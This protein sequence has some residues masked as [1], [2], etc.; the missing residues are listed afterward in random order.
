MSH[1]MQQL[2]FLIVITNAGGQGKT[3]LARLCKSLWLMAGRDVQLL[4][5]DP[6]SAMARMLDEHAKRVGWGVD[7]SFAPSIVSACEGQHVVLDCGANLMASHREIVDFVPEL[8][9]RFD[10]AGYRTVVL[11]PFTPNKPGAV[12][13]LEELAPKLPPME[14]IVVRNN[15]NASGQFEQTNGGLPIIGLGHLMPGMVSY[16]DETAPASFFDVVQTPAPGH[17]LVG[18]YIGEWMWAFARQASVHGLFGETLSH[19][20][21]IPAEPKLWFAVDSI[22]DCTDDA[23][24][25]NQFNSRILV[26]I[27]SNGWTSEGLRRAANQLDRRLATA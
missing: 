14:T 27:E 21:A 24:R 11:M 5:S 17:G 4:C 20:D 13:L 15:M 12:G 6:G 26:D 7:N 23:L 2:I 18:R 25:V 19:L 16:L 22:G 9:R 8:A 3:L 1:A 10:A